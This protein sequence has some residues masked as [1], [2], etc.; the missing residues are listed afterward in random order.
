[1]E[2][3]NF[4]KVRKDGEVLGKNCEA[5]PTLPGLNPWEQRRVSPKNPKRA[6]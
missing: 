3:K 5:K 1:M 4:A 6:P 2:M